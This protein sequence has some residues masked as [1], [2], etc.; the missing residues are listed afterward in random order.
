MNFGKAAHKAN[1]LGLSGKEREGGV[2]WL[3]WSLQAQQGDPNVFLS[4]REGMKNSVYLH[5]AHG[6]ANYL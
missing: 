3:S 2:A 6:A 4:V 5:A 1:T